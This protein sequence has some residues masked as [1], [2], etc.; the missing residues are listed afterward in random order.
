MESVNPFYLLGLTDTHLRGS[1]PSACR[2]CG[3]L[4]VLLLWMRKP[5]LAQL[6][7]SVSEASQ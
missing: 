4:V 3:L 6:V 2:A 7:L 5:T 1:G